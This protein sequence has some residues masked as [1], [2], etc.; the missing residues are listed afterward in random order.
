MKEEEV[1]IETTE[2]A[3]LISGRKSNASITLQSEITLPILDISEKKTWTALPEGFSKAVKF[4]LFSAGVDMTK[5][6]LSCVNIDG[7]FVQTCDNFRL[8]RY[9]LPGKGIKSPM[10]IPASACAELIKYDPTHYA[11]DESWAHFMNK[12]GTEFSCRVVEGKFPDLQSFIDKKTNNKLQLNEDTSDILDRA[13]VFLG[14]NSQYVK[15]SISSNFMTIRADGNV[16]WFKE[17][18]RVDYKGELIEFMIN[19]T[20]L[21]DMIA[22]LRDVSIDESKALLKF[23]GENFVHCCA[24]SVPEEKK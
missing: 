21:K 6:E 1:D 10:L 22:V 13:I 14:D 2:T 17:K 15:I 18:A 5:P 12:E 19:P 24:V 23:E 7:K 8:T 11:V 9:T 16:G 20:F 3:M 4:S